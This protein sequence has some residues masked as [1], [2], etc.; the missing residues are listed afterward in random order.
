MSIYKY[1]HFV[2]FAIG[3]KISPIARKFLTFFLTSDNLSHIAAHGPA[4]GCGRGG[5]DIH[6]IIFEA[7][8]QGPARTVHS[9]G[10]AALW[11]LLTRSGATQGRDDNHDIQ[12]RA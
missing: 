4:G 1:L 11:F 5:D 12:F 10:A 2:F 6:A 9:A 8:C 7:V 3:L